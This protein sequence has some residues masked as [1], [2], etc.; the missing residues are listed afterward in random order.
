MERSMVRNGKAILKQN[1]EN[2]IEYL[3][4]PIL[5]QTGSVNHLFTTRIGG[6]SEGVFRSMNLSFTRGDNPKDVMENFHRI[7]AL[8][9]GTPED[10]VCS[11]Q[12]HTAN[13]RR[14]T[15]ADR[16]KGV[17]CAKDYHDV[18]G[19]ITN[20]PGLI[21]S[22]FYADCVPLY[23]VD[24][25]RK[26]IGLAH[27]G[28]KG[29]VGGIGP[30]TLQAMAA[31]FG[32]CPEETYAAIGPSICGDCYEIGEDVAERFMNLFSHRERNG[33]IL[34]EGKEPG[35]YQ[36]D[37]REAN[38][39]LLLKAGILPEHLEVADLCTCCNPDYLF[40]HRAS[41]GKRGNLGAFLSILRKY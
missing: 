9:D 40:S 12:T 8:F 18:D 35:K 24:D 17:V 7:A 30:K 11:D 20:V 5:E 19:L 10:F 37:L 6:V 33:K 36:L 38:R 16:G 29:T 22:T 34:W 21:L 41:N 32:T 31:A 2:G 4:F 1:M 39:C 26:A 28:W 14:V 3:T 23:F 13:I 27:S 25:K 15:A